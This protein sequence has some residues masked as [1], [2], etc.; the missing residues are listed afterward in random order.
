MIRPLAGALGKRSLR[1]HAASEP[2]PSQNAKEVCDLSDGPVAV[3][4]RWARGGVTTLCP[5]PR[6][7][8]LASLDAVALD[9]WL[10]GLPFVKELSEPPGVLV[11]QHREANASEGPIAV[12]D[13]TLHEQRLDWPLRG[14]TSSSFSIR[15]A[16]HRGQEASE[17][18]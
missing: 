2:S 13:A 3:F 12:T 7:A 6:C 5:R 17:R 8:C 15:Q 4:A 18:S 1:G 16:H 11:P 14:A 9:D 10:P